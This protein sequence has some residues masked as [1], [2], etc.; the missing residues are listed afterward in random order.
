MR[1]GVPLVAALMLIIGNNCTVL[2]ADSNYNSRIAEAE[3]R[4]DA[5]DYSSAQREFSG[6]LADLDKS[7]Q[8]GEIKWRAAYTLGLTYIQLEQNDQAD[9]ALAKAL[10]I[11]EKL[12]QT[13][14]GMLANTLLAIGDVRQ[15]QNKYTE[16]AELYKKA[17]E[18]SKNS[19]DEAIV[20]ARAVDGLAREA[21]HTGHYDR[22]QALFKESLTIREKAL[23]AN[24]PGC[25]FL[26]RQ[27]ADA[28]RGVRGNLAAKELEAQARQLE[29]EKTGQAMPQQ[30]DA[31]NCL[32]V[33]QLEKDQFSAAEESFKKALSLAEKHLS[34]SHPLVSS[35]LVN[36]GALYGIEHKNDESEATLRRALSVALKVYG[37]DSWMCSAVLK[38]LAILN[39]YEKHFILAEKLMKQG[40]A[41]DERVFGHD[42]KDVASIVGNLGSLYL[43]EHRYG[44]AEKC[45]LEEQK[46]FE[47]LPDKKPSDSAGCYYDFAALYDAQNKYPEAETAIRNAIPWQEKAY[48]LDSVRTASYLNVLASILYREGKYAEAEPVNKRAFFIVE[49]H[50]DRKDRNFIAALQSYT[51][52]L[53]KLNKIAEADALENKYRCN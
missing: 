39:M 44:D 53:R 21:V 5:G 11:A 27:Y 6:I 31:I 19:K 41:I 22:A 2:C 8:Y 18:A 28:L 34:P 48:G 9:A 14:K 4:F 49:K 17:I 40:M 45:Y 42:S 32:G 23:G 3:A 10:P 15:M 20:H 30:I 24:D 7:P 46:I 38:N 16:A 1:V 35:I 29:R 36:L 47:R 12:S 26:L 52:I 13:D 37:P 33:A 25:I 51:G 50:L 43:N